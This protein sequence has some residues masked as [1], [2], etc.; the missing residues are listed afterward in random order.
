MVPYIILSHSENSL[1]NE[2]EKKTLIVDVEPIVGKNPMVPPKLGYT[3]I[4][5]DLRQVPE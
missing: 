5:M 4:N 2:E 1:E 3:K